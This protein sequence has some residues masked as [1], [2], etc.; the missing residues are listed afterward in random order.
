M[1]RL[2][3]IIFLIINVL[4]V[5]QNSM[6]K[7]EETTQKIATT[8]YVIDNFYVDS[9]D[10][11][12]LTEEAIVAM[13]KSLDP[14]SAY[15]AAKD[16]QKANEEL[17][18]SFE[19]IGV[20]F[21]I[22]RD[23]I[24]VVSAVP[25]G[26]AE[27]VGIMAGDRIVAIDGEDAVGKKVN[28]EYV[29]KHLRGEKGTKAVLGIK[30]GHDTEIIDFEVVR[31]KIPLNSINTYFMIDKETGYIKLDKFS[32]QSVEEFQ[33]ALDDLKNQGMHSLVFDLRGN[34][35][36]FLHI[37][38]GLGNEFLGSGKT[39]VFTE[40]RHSP[41]QVFKTD[42]NGGFCEGRLVV[43]IDEGSA[44]AS[45]IVSG[46]IQD[47]DRGVLIGRRSFGK[48]LVQRPFNLPDGSQI[49]LTTARYYT[50][51]G[52]CIQRS[53]EEGSEEYFKEMTKRFE[54]GE[55]YHAD[56]IYFPDSLRYLTLTSGRTVYGG[57]GIMPDIFMPM[58]TAVST[59]LLT[60]LIRKTV[61]NTYC[62]DYVMENRKTIQKKYPDFEKFNKEFEIDDAMS[63]DL[64]KVAIQKNVEWN[65]EQYERSK[66]W[67]RLRIKAMIAD[68]L[69][70]IDKY[71]QVVAKADKMIERALE[72][73]N[74]PQEYDEILG[75]DLKK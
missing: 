5:A 67:I 14:H 69:W 12:K 2:F 39:V 31:D 73:I 74:S 15:I 45:E 18:G 35:G 56:S 51:T 46:A 4:C 25:G 37:A 65:D 33:K 70:N 50:P 13:L 38:F 53:Y 40:G 29:T 42:R 34:T 59:K 8:M 20:T 48:G 7:Q 9:T 60:D 57:G 21:Q 64:R 16:V 6:V 24:L 62:I 11:S 75:K 61:F 19:G 32:Q 54:H 52:R 22:L 44:S 68:N 26:P 3:L 10:M 58:D 1:K 66:E 71:Y 43:L 41:K 72:I 49:R 55:Y 27:K 17:V 63:D 28:N 23:T 47:W 30:R 36:G